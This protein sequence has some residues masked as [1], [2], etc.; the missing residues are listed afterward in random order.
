MKRAT[1][2]I[3]ILLLASC[4]QQP[5]GQAPPIRHGRYAGIGTYSAGQLWSRMAIGVKPADKAAA[6]IQD[7]DEIIVSVDSYTGEVRQCGN[8][9]GYCIGMNPW[10][11]ETQATPAKLTAHA[12]DVASETAEDVNEVAPATHED[13]RG[14]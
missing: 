8:L 4:D 2:L 11:G 14:R 9:S 6:T 13:E 7:D 10:T 5:A 3:L 1:A 12:A